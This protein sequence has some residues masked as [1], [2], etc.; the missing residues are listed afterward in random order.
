MDNIFSAVI[1][2][3]LMEMERVTG[4]LNSF[5]KSHQIEEK[6]RYRINLAI[7]E[8]LINI[9]TYGSKTDKP[10]IIEIEIELHPEEV[11]ILLTDNGR[12][13]NPLSIPRLDIKK[14]AIDRPAGGL[15][16]HLVRHIMQAM[17]YER[18]DEKNIFKIYLTR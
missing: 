10:L 4:D 7:E 17:W 18:K 14:P 3:D 2:D 16:M 9:I 1:T 5:L 13:F 8:P 11:S 15:G 12:R 6:L